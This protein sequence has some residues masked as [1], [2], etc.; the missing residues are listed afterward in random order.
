M[1]STQ[2]HA[3]QEELEGVNA[4]LSRALLVANE[5][6]RG[7]LTD[8]A[9]GQAGLRLGGNS[10]T[11]V[12]VKTAADA[13]SMLADKVGA[14]TQQL[15]AAQARAEM[16]E[17]T[18][19]ARTNVGAGMGTPAG[20]V[21]GTPLAASRMSAGVTPLMRGSGGAAAAADDGTNEL[22]NRQKQQ[23]GEMQQKW[24]LSSV[25]TPGAGGGGG[26]ALFNRHREQQQRIES[27][28]KSAM[29]VRSAAAAGLST[30]LAAGTG[31]GAGAST[32]A[33]ARAP[34]PGTQAL[35]E[36]LKKAQAAFKTLSRN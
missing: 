32:G 9:D 15:I 21:A 18:S 2:F 6:S 31:A 17:V 14:V 3:C 7:S 1:L 4:E 12:V 19:L 16:A 27:V 30:P 35:Q 26:S 20:S 22:L 29:S 8:P 25:E 5:R 10:P 34:S 24:G 33:R 13:L 28:T 23:L 11:G 36:R